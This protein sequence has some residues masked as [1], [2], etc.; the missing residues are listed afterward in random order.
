MKITITGVTGFVGS[1]LFEN[2]LEHNCEPNALN[3]RKPNWK[4]EIETEAKAIIHLAG[5]AHDTKNTSNPKDYFDIN[6]KLTQ[7]LFDVFLESNCRDFIFFSSVKAVT[8]KAEDIVTEETITNPQTAYGQSKLQAEQYIL[9]KTLPQG[10]RIFIIR[11][12]MIHGPGNKGNL[13]LLYQLVSKGIPWPLGAFHNQRSFC[14]IDNVCYVVNQILERE[15]I[16]SGVYNLADD[17][18]LSTN[19]LI[20]LIASSTNRK[21]RIFPIPKILINTIAKI[22]D[23][24]HLP[25]NTERLDKLTENFVVSNTKIKAALQIEKLPFNAREGFLKTV[26]NLSNN[27]KKNNGSRIY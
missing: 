22:G 19:E 21:V 9:S 25:L 11:P 13:N 6:T 18:T 20:E 12:S 23:I 8:D 10:K 15:D 27:L 3:L 26:K 14:S 4:S 24:L 7:D 5:K 1:N 16:P 2:L 17:D